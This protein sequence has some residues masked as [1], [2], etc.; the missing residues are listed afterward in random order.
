MN[1]T[2]L[3]YYLLTLNQWADSKKETGVKVSAKRSGGRGRATDSDINWTNSLILK[4]RYSLVVV[5]TSGAYSLWNNRGLLSYTKLLLITATRLAG[6]GGGALNSIP[7]PPRQKREETLSQEKGIIKIL[8]YS[9]P[10][11][12]LPRS[13]KHLI[14]NLRSPSTNLHNFSYS[15]IST[16]VSRTIC[17]FV[18]L[19]HKQKNSLDS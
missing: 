2:D 14:V 15:L 19:K 7:G 10:H 18:K 9:P 13:V 12:A 8:D 11:R 16:I 17:N 5:E 6:G 3:Y 4:L 1:R